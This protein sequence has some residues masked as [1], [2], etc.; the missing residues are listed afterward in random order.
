MPSL[1]ATM[2][3]VTYVQGRMLSLVSF[4]AAFS[5]C[6]GGCARTFLASRTKGNRPDRWHAG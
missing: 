4:T 1:A 6:Y 3:E 5:V 2:Y